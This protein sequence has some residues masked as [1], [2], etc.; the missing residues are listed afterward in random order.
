MWR[1]RPNTPAPLW[2]WDMLDQFKTLFDYNYWAN[3]RILRAAG[4]VTD[5]QFVAPG[6]YGWGG[7]RGTLVHTMATEWIWRSRW[8]GRSPKKSL[9][10][11]D[12]GT[13]AALRERWRE[14]EDKMREFLAPLTEQ[15]L[16]RRVT[17][18]RMSGGA[19]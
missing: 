14:E 8:L 5:E 18:E 15:D 13:V 7:L 10:L 3:G 1:K 19:S 11:E 12:Y 6:D 17:Y 9:P 16:E 2:W 4:A